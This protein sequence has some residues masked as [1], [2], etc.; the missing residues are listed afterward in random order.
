[1]TAEAAVKTPVLKDSNKVLYIGNAGYKIAISNTMSKSLI[2]YVSKNS[3]VAAVSKA[4][5]ITPRAAGTT[6]I[7]VT[8]KQDNHTYKLTL[9]ITVKKPYIA[10]TKSIKSLTVN[11]TYQFKAAAYG[12]DSKIT[13]SVSDQSIASVNTY[14]KLTALKPG[15]V[16]V[17]AKAGGKSAYCSIVIKSAVTG[18]SDNTSTKTVLSAADLYEKCNPSIVEIAVQGKYFS[19][20]GSGFFIDK[21]TIVTNYHVIKGANS[22]QVTTNDKVVHD[23][24]T[25]IGYNEKLDLA[26]LKVEADFK[27]LV[28][29]KAAGRAGEDVYALGSPLGLTGTI[30]RGIITTASREYDGVDYIQTDAPISPGNSGGPLLNV[31]GEVIGVNTMY[32]PDGQ[33]LNFSINIS[34]LKEVDTGKPVSVSDYYDAYEEDF[35]DNAII[36]DTS[37][38]NLPAKGQ[39]IMPSTGVK[40]TFKSNSNS[41]QYRFTVMEPGWIQGIVQTDNE[42]DLDNIELQLLN[43][44]ISPDSFFIN[45]EGSYMEVSFYLNPGN[46]TLMLSM[47]DKAVTH[48]VPYFFFFEY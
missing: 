39:Q 23:V 36:E 37:L 38:T 5:T 25:I 43:S 4:G 24:D 10:F 15:Q 29:S 21:N 20:L 48:E 18:S 12:I 47:E 13:W 14:G 32:Y 8:V 46:Y 26:I 16:K 31:Y 41:D 11:G 6:S 27:P 2:T 28:I 22:I 35:K 1:M 30:S 3:T 33:N 42:N 19:A 9:S 45:K 7:L 17:Y 40:G 44:G 34:Q